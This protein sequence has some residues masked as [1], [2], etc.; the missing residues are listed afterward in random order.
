MTFGAEA[1][2]YREIL[3]LLGMLR[4]KLRAL[5]TPFEQVFVHDGWELHVRMGLSEF[6]YLEGRA[7]GFPIAWELLNSQR[8][9]TPPPVSD[10]SL[11]ATVREILVEAI[12][13]IDRR[14]P[15]PQPLYK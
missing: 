5:K 11:F 10:T 7:L 1:E 8:A 2:R 12:V 14:A 9:P 4:E 6:V 15:R 3:R 13:E